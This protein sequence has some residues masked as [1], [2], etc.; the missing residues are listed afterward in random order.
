MRC[1]LLVSMLALSLVACSRQETAW[2]SASSSDTT[3][4]YERYLRDYPAGPHASDARDRLM[5]LRERQEWDRASRLST[6]EA[7]QR[8]LAGYPEGRF[9]A[10]A[11]VRLADFLVVQGQPDIDLAQAPVP[12]ALLE[13]AA[14]GHH[15]IQLGAFGGGE[16]VA[17]RAWGDIATKHADLVGGMTP[18]VDAVDRDGQIYWRLQAGPASEAR[19]REI[20]TALAARGAGCVVVR[21]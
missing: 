11:R 13:Q 4:A 19:A 6:P 9:A 12:G 10:E 2:S 15:R 17:R 5:E 21:D 14:V 7:Y 20:C 3:T 8:Y 16:A 18:R 1:A